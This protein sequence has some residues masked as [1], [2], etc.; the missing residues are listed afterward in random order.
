MGLFVVFV[1]LLVLFVRGLLVLFVVQFLDLHAIPLA[2]Q[3]VEQIAE[4]VVGSCTEH[5]G[6]FKT[7]TRSPLSR[8]S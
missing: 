1:F 8:P 7:G 2:G 3:V 4:G 5:Y 6:V